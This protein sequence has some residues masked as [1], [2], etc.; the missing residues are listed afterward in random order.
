ME[1]DEAH[2]IDNVCIEALSVDLEEPVFL[3]ASQNITQLNSIIHLK[4]KEAGEQF[5][6]EYI[7]IVSG[8]SGIPFMNRNSQPSTQLTVNVDDVPLASVTPDDAPPES[9]PEPIRKAEE[10]VNFLRKLIAFL[11]GYVR[12][13]T[14]TQEKPIP[15]LRSLANACNVQD[16]NIFRVT[17]SRLVSLLITAHV[18]SLSEFRPLL[19]IADFVTTLA[20]YER[21]GMSVILEP[22]NDFTG[23][24]EPVLRLACLDASL[25]IRWIT[26]KFRNVVITSGT[27]SPLDTYPRML[28]FPVVVSASMNMSMERRCVCPLIMCKGADQTVMSSKYNDRQTED[29]PRNY[30]HA[31]IQLAC[32]VPDGIVAF[33]V[34]YVF[35]QQVIKCW[36]DC[37]LLEEL[38]QEKLLFVET[39]DQMEASLA[40]K[41]YKA[42]CDSGRGAIL[43]S[44][45]RG[46]AAEGIDLDLQYGRCCI[47]FGVPFQY[48]ESRVLQARL[49]FLSE[50]FQ[51][52]EDDFLIFDVSQKSLSIFD[53]RLIFALQ[54]HILT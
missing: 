10:F 48:T 26:Q 4:K 40:I 41:N 43:L 29:I 33:F 19:V 42:A 16:S 24:Y 6:A 15:F 28:D 5:R 22:Y 49:Q 36:C 37:G 18:S 23:E 27:L 3:S 8:L 54:H 53:R 52:R 20:T 25:A 21:E 2:N 45:A 12:T 44:V 39:Q 51:I 47:L 17:H 1:L 14:A 13:E 7:R 9:V 31:L 50:K 11:N 38:R 32:N 35:M 34:S 46:R 30:G